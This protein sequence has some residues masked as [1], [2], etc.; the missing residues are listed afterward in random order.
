MTVPFPLYWTE[1]LGPL[2]LVM[3]ETS[4]RYLCGLI[5]IAE[6]FTVVCRVLKLFNR[7]IVIISIVHDLV[8]TLVELY[9]F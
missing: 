4:F 1:V 3:Y 5:P 9:V 8:S 2:K 7:D 6:M